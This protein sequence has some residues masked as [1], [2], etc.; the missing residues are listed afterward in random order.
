MLVHRYDGERELLRPL[1]READ[2][3]EQQINT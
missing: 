2:D 3:S 1:F